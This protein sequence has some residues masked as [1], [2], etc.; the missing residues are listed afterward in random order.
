MVVMLVAML[1]ALS[2][3]VKDVNWAVAMV[4]ML[5]DYLVL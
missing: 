2:V 5:V 1:A 4:V 3:A